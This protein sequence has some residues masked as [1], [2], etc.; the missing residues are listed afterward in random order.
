MA[1]GILLDN[2]QLL[3]VTLDQD[4]YK[5]NYG[6]H[7][8]QKFHKD[9]LASL[10]IS[11]IQLVIMGVK[12]TKLSEIFGIHRKTIEKWEKVSKEQGL[13]RLITME[14]G[15]PS[16]CE[17]TIKRYIIDLDEKLNKIKKYKEIIID[18]VNKL[19]GITISREII[20]KVLQENKDSKKQKDE[21]YS[22]NEDAPGSKEEI[23]DVKNGGVL[24]ALPFLEKLCINKLIPTITKK[25][26]GYTFREILMTLSMLITGGLLKNEEQIKVN[27]SASM[28]AIIGKGQLPSLR[29]LR[30]LIPELI[31]GINIKN[32]KKNFT[33]MFLKLY[34]ER[35][36]FYV[37][38]HFMPYHGKEKIFYGYNSIRRIAMKGRTSYVVNTES[39]RPIYQ[40][41]SDNFDNFYDNLKKIIIFIKEISQGII[42][43]LVFDRGGFGEDFFNSIHEEALF[44]CWN[45]GKIAAPANGEWK[46]VPQY[47]ESNIWGQKEKKIFQVKEEK[48]KMK[49]NNGSYIIRRFFIK[50]GDKISAAV[51][52]DLEKKIEDLVKILTRRWGAQEN[53]FKDLKK[54]G[55]DN[56][57]SYW[58]DEYSDEILFE[59]EIDIEKEM[60]NPEYTSAVEERKKLKLSLDKLE[61]K[62]GEL[63]LKIKNIA[64]PTKSIIKLKEKINMIEKA[65][66]I[67]N[68]RINY[69]PDKILRYDY[70][71]DNNI[72][73]LASDKKEYFDLLKFISYNVRRDIAEIVGPVYKNNRDIHTIIVKWLQS[74]CT[75]QKN[76]NELIVN[77]CCPDNKTEEDA[78][79]KLCEYLNTLNYK[80]FKSGEKMRF[81]VAQSM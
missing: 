79:K 77:L 63:F 56:I 50:K 15:R 51:T 41:L 74:K 44:I 64:K 22:Q 49:S 16:K 52:N 20:R 26:N 62:V 10:K 67:A 14:D 29:T 18:E 59:N 27:D 60:T 72:L 78:L 36:I 13:I 76:N 35:M 68:D 30:R 46:D 65:I 3:E 21:N 24:L 53:V 57:H 5:I 32:I 61:A 69:L 70:M 80:H 19:F 55:Y 11:V 73:K 9:D 28:G 37:D 40:I 48:I 43:L 7:T 66:E 75:L 71:K 54:I 34:N 4:Y 2:S 12:R 33:A 8:F 6:F 42:P 38:G 31:E 58:K 39:G 23:T 1:Q 45:K 81:Q 17:E 25:T 47:F